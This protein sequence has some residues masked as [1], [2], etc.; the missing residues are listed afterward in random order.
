MSSPITRRELFQVGTALVVGSAA[1]AETGN[2]FACGTRVR[3]TA[4]LVDADSNV[5][6]AFGR[7]AAADGV[8]VQSI[9]D[10]LTDV[11][12]DQLAPQW[13]KGAKTAVGGL[14]GAAPLF[15]LERLAWD[16]GM[17]VVF[18]GRHEITG[19]APPKHALRGPRLPIDVF[20]DSVR[21]LEW[22]LA[23]AE[24]LREIPVHAP[25]LQPVSF[26]RDAVVAGDCA[27]FSWVL[28]PV[29]NDRTGRARS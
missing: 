18:L 28:A 3:L 23:L 14:T 9:R 4:M 7:I 13:R 19:D 27:L 17:R 5:A 1:L 8:P 25:A 6:Q 11:Y 10:D 29:S 12:C 15:Y 26:V 20:H 21:W 24:T 2:A 16:A 22:P